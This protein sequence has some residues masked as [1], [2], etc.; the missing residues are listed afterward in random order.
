VLLGLVGFAYGVFAIVLLLFIMGATAGLLNVHT[1]AWI[2][3]RIDDAVRG[4]VASV[5]M[6]A[7]VGIAPISLAVA[8]LMIAWNLKLMFLFAGGLM[9]VA[10]V[11]AALQQTVR[12]I[13]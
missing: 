5:L 10:A 1:T 4:R 11:V 8:G 9:L 13:E 2:M 7:S 3:Q 12:E 6:P